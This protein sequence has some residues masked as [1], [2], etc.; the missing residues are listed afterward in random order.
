V[1]ASFLSLCVGEKL[2]NP[3]KSLP[4]IIVSVSQGG[5]PPLFFSAVEEGKHALLTFLRGDPRSFWNER[6]DS[7]TNFIM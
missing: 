3:E 7:T 6:S 4:K 1:N 5:S 2:A